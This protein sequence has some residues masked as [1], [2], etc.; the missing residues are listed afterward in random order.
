MGTRAHW[1][2]ESGYFAVEVDE[3]GEDRLTKK[4]VIGI[5][6]A[7]E[8]F[9]HADAMRVYRQGRWGNRLHGTYVRKGNRLVKI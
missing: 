1:F 4:Y 6:D 7:K 5:T 8:E 9:A 2:Y 3:D